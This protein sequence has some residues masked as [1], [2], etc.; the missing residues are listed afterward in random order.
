[1]RKS[2]SIN[3]VEI[4]R[5]N[6]EFVTYFPIVMKFGSILNYEVFSLQFSEFT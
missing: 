2:Y 3:F 5:D 1:M 6:T 4:R